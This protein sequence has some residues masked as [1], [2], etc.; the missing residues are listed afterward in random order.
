MSSENGSDPTSTPSKASSHH[1]GHGHKGKQSGLNAD[2]R[3]LNK[4]R[5]SFQGVSSSDVF[6]DAK[7]K[8]FFTI[9]LKYGF[10]KNYASGK[11]Y[12]GV[13]SKVGGHYDHGHIGALSIPF[14]TVEK[15]NGKI[16][17]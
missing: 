13:N 7:N 9:A 5:K 8:E 1:A 16:V 3:Y 15:I 4:N 12:S 17:Q 2:F 11:T 14:E 6:D 10:N